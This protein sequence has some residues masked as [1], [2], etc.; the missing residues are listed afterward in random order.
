MAEYHLVY[1][2][3]ICRLSAKDWDQLWTQC[4]YISMGYLYV[5][6]LQTTSF[7]LS[8]LMLLLRQQQSRAVINH[9]PPMITSYTFHHQTFL[10]TENRKMHTN[11]PE[12]IGSDQGS[13]TRPMPIT[14]QA[15]ST[16]RLTHQQLCAKCKK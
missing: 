7:S 6:K 11:N 4:S 13:E 12:V 2:Y 9:M 1:D 5:F 8:A 15:V 14:I 10:S 16:N 3:V